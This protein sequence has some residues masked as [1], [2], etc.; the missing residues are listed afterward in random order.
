MDIKT[1][2]DMWYVKSFNFTGWDASK[3]DIYGAK[4]QIDEMIVRCAV[5]TVTI[6]VVARQEHSYS[7]VIDWNG[8]HILRDDQ[9]E[10]LITYTKSRG[11][12]VILKPMLNTMDGYW[13]AYIRFFDE[14]V[15][16]EPKWSDWFQSYTE[17]ML[18]FAELAEKNKVDML[19]IGC[20]L[21]GTD[22]KAVEWRKL[23]SEVRKVY[24]GLITYNCDK[25]QEHN[26]IWWDVLDVISSS[27][28][29]PIGDW[30][31]QLQRIEGVVRKFNKPF[32]FSEAGCPSTAG[33]AQVPNDWQVI[34]K[35]SVDLEEQANYF[36]TM[37]ENC[38]KVKWHY[39]YSI[40]DWPMSR[41]FPKIYDNKGG[42]D[43]I[44]K[45]A[46]EVVLKFFEKFNC[47]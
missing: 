9:I 5:N 36:T 17:Y 35:G 2:K 3:I 22:H 13:R 42:Y 40:W 27:G 18:H 34:G 11:Q 37:F 33:A 1:S 14:D 19:I 31:N 44:D 39:G 21:V 30:K 47:C 12:K 28:Y 29:Y 38:S 23:V 32:F 41:M 4:A 16:C 10:E 26:V 8:N 46:Q 25:Y 20:E 43:V 24:S 6:A 45:P 15:P 7:T